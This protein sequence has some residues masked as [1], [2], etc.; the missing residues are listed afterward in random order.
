MLYE[1]RAAGPI[2]APL[3]A[4][5]GAR[6]ACDFEIPLHDAEAQAR[7]GP[8]GLPR[9]AHAFAW[10]DQPGRPGPTPDRPRRPRSRPCLAGRLSRCDAMSDG[11]RGVSLSDGG[12]GEIPRP[13]E[14]TIVT[15]GMVSVKPPITIGQFSYLLLPS[16]AARTARDSGANR[17]NQRAA[18]ALFYPGDSVH[19]PG[20]Q[21][22][23]ETGAWSARGCE[24][25]RQQRFVR[26]EK[27]G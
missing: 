20:S 25:A 7:K 15:A 5:R 3:V 23:P 12:P 13:K 4:P 1:P 8:S 22:N 10:S 6:R 17:D 2:H 21:V 11:F 27:E 19:H 9:A 26:G 14:D 18:A 16:P 24:L